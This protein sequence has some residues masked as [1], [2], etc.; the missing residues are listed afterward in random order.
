MRIRHHDISRCHNPQ[1]IS[2]KLL[3]AVDKASQVNQIHAAE[4]KEANFWKRI[5]GNKVR[6]DERGPVEV[7]GKAAD[8]SDD[9]VGN[10]PAVPAQRW[11]RVYSKFVTMVGLLG[12]G[13]LLASQLPSVAKAMRAV[14]SGLCKAMRAAGRAIVR[15]GLAAVGK[16]IFSQLSSRLVGLLVHIAPHILHGVFGAVV[17]GILGGVVAR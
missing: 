16:V 9:A 4:P 11:V 10:Q 15:K 2:Q 13:L 6:T 7:T 8:V 17:L 3:A 12:G 1:P 5:F 14:Y